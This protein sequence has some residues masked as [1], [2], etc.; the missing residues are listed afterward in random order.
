MY[1]KRLQLVRQTMLKEG[2]TALYVTKP[3][4][5][6]YL[7]G[8]T[9]TSGSL[10]ITMDEAILITDF[11][12][13]EQA[14]EQSTHTRVVVAT[15][16]YLNTIAE[17]GEN[18]DLNQFGVEGSHITYQ[19][20]QFL[21][22][23]LKKYNILPLYN[24]LEKIRI[25]KDTDEVAKLAKAAALADKTMDMIFPLI[26]EGISEKELS[27]EIEFFFKRN[28]AQAL[29]FNMI[30]ASGTRSAMPH[31]TATNK[32]LM[33]GELLTMDFGALLDGYNSDITRTVAVGSKDK[34]MNELYKIVLEAQLT[35]IEKVREGVLASEVDKATREVI[36]RYGYGDFFGHSTGHGIGLEIH[37]NPKLSGNDS[38]ILKNGMVITVE[39]GIY[40]PG[41]GGIR[42]EDTVL[43]EDNGYSLLTATPKE[44]LMVCG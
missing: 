13:R 23:N 34:K 36:Q 6:F 42:I 8:F 37:E 20:F 3:E 18:S 40:L 26:K 25:I 32:K 27:L 30:V 29:A 19:H 9:G 41:W 28:G 43:V 44:H 22:D 2:I 24:F 10:I 33:V 5:R 7:S 14:I 35:G 15:G 31:G 39:P 11:R 17:I 4:N 21:K 12:Y 38:T 1:K 16:S